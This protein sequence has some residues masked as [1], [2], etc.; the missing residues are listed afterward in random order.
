[1]TTTDSNLIE[2]SEQ[3]YSIDK[4][5]FDIFTKK[6]VYSYYLTELF[7]FFIVRIRV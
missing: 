7:L 3:V 1:M 4:R 5:S 2:K 6:I